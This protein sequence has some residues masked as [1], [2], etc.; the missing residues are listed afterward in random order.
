MLKL[1]EIHVLA[2]VTSHGLLI[3]DDL[4]I[5]RCFGC[6]FYFIDYYFT[7][8]WCEILNELFNN[9]SSLTVPFEIR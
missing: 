4:C 8:S 5:Y 2:I 7:F 6:D 9:A 1:S 3:M